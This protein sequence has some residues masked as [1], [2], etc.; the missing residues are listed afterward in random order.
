MSLKVWVDEVQKSQGQ[1]SKID[2]VEELKKGHI[3]T[4]QGSLRGKQKR[5]GSKGWVS[6]PLLALNK[7]GCFM[8]AWLR[9]TEHLGCTEKGWSNFHTS[10]TNSPGFIAIIPHCLVTQLWCITQLEGTASIPFPN[11]HAGFSRARKKVT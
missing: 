6:S 11:S 9:K 10:R 8:E 3:W 7:P 1:V 2:V 5:G 4:K